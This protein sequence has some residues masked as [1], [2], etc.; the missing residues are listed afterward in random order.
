VNAAEKR[1]RELARQLQQNVRPAAQP[2]SGVCTASHAELVVA[3]RNFAA[4]SVLGRGCF[5]PVYRG[6]WGGQAVAIKRLDQASPPLRSLPATS[7]P[8]IFSASNQICFS[9]KRL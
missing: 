3:T 8:E 1:L 5:G 7:Q 2:L 9:A 4:G 6:E